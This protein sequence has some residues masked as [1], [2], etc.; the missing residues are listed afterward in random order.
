MEENSERVTRKVIEQRYNTREEW[1]TL[2]IYY[3]VFPIFNLSL[4]KQQ[5][6]KI[7]DDELFKASIYKY[8]E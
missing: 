8:K 2:K 5:E 4:S 3:K 7:I 6:K 1:N